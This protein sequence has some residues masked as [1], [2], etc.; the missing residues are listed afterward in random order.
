MFDSGKYIFWS[1]LSINPKPSFEVNG[2]SL[3]W[4]PNPPSLV[5]GGPLVHEPTVLRGELQ[6]EPAALSLPDSCQYLHLVSFAPDMQ[7]IYV[8]E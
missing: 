6:Q 4:L 5:M 2:G 8:E 3:Q 7:T 1:K